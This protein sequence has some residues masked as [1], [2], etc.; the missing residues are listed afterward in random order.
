[1]QCSAS[2]GMKAF[3]DMMHEAPLKYMLFGDACTQVTDPIAKASRYWKVAQLSYADMHPMF[4]LVRIV[5]STS[6]ELFT[7]LFWQNIM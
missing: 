1:M 4:R 2:D 6:T 5:F 3:F 7:E